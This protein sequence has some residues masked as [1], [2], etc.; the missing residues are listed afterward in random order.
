MEQQMEHP[1][2]GPALQAQI[3]AQAEPRQEGDPHYWY[4]YAGGGHKISMGAPSLAELMADISAFFGPEAGDI[5]VAKLSDLAL[6]TSVLAAGLASQADSP[7]MPA[8]GFKPCR[9]CGGPLDKFVP[10]GTSSR[11]GKPYNSFYGCSNPNCR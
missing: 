11:T 6:G 7:P 1:V 4:S 2:P 8:G 3:R 10:G 9:K 5:I